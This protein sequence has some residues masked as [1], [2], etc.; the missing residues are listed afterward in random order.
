MDSPSSSEGGLMILDGGIRR[1]VIPRRH[2]SIRAVGIKKADGGIGGGSDPGDVASGDGLG[3]EQGM[4]PRGL[5][6]T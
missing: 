2:M 6:I 1:G 3:V 5:P 4:P